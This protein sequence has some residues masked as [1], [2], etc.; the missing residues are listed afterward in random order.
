MSKPDI[1]MSYNVNYGEKMPQ[2]I[3]WMQDVPLDQRPQI[4]CFQEMPEP[5]LNRLA[6]KLGQIGYSTL[7]FAS[8]IKKDGQT[9]GQ[10]TA[11]G[12]RGR[13]LSDRVVNFG[14]SK[15]ERVYPGIKGRSGRRSAL[16]TQ[17]QTAQDRVLQVVNIHQP[18]I[19]S[20]GERV[21]NLA[22]VDQG[23]D[24]SIPAIIAGDQNFATFLRFSDK[25]WLVDQMAE[26]GFIDS[27]NREPTFGWGGMKWT[28]DYIGAR[29]VELRNPQVKKI[30]LS[31]HDPLFVEI[32]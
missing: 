25:N 27:G 14:L 8:A 13:L 16:V 12:L 26:M 29:G 6:G 11:V 9:F 28:V 7:R 5:Y 30:G 22:Q 32:Y 19:A 18:L 15:K 4:V 10:L 1:I 2:I 21:R 23:L 20:G 24:P 31:D 17:I 3:E